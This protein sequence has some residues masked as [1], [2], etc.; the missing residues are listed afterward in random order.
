MTIEAPPVQPVRQVGD[1]LLLPHKRAC[2]VA[3]GAPRP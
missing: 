1:I 2:G 3:P